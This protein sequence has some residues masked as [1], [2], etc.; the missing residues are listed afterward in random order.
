MILVGTSNSVWVLFQ[1]SRP[2]RAFD[3][4]FRN[5]ID[6]LIGKLALGGHLKL[7]LIMQ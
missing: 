4:P 6:H 7:T 3:Y 2:G 5:I 1:V